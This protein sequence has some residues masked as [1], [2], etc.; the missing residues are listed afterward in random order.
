MRL[1]ELNALDAAAAARELLRCCGSPR[2]AEQMAD[3]RPFAGAEAMA[4]AADSA[5]E[6]LDRADWL[7]AFAAHPKIGAGGAG[8]GPGSAKAAAERGV[9]ADWSEQEQA[10]VADAAGATLL[11]LAGANRDYEARFG[12][13]FIVCA[14]GKSAAEMLRSARAPDGQRPGDRD[15]HRGGRAAEDYAAAA[16]E[17]RRRETGYQP[18]ITTHVLDIAR[19]EPAEGVTVILELRQASEW[20]PIGRG[21]TD[22]KGRVTTLTDG[23][24]R[25]RDL[26]ADVRHRHVPP[27][28]RPRGP[29]LSRSED[30]LQRARPGR[31]LSPAAA[32]QSVRLHAPTVEHD[33]ESGM[34]PRRCLS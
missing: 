21:T 10:R 9:A 5:F 34:K 18:M 14:T 16:D 13:I 3:A 11:R 30:H 27:R 25:A 20:T 29:V 15:S 28:A 6:R 2:W 19:G 33:S 32:P 26:S 22:G 1:E 23:A 7:E 17:A 31:A 12:Y 4:A 8:A 24:A